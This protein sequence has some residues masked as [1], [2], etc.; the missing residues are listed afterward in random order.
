MFIEEGLRMGLQ[1]RAIETRIRILQAAEE[2]FALEGYDATGVAEICQEAGVSKGA[3]YH[4]FDSKQEVFLELLAD[5]LAEMDKQL[6]LL[7]KAKG[8]VPERI[9]SM[10]RV[11]RVV[12]QA[13][14]RGLPIY[15]E[16]WSRA[17]RDPEVMET[18]IEP[19]R[20]Y[21][22]FFTEMLEEGAQ[23][24]TLDL[25]DPHIAAQVVLSLALG[26]LVQGIFDPEGADWERV[27]AEGIG[28]VLK[29]YE[30]R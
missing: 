9:L 14:Q 29:G 30:K 21:R 18:M 13:A 20:K 7:G 15:L 12:L 16:F 19:F 26:L 8:N 1:Q 28:V 3:F 17:L 25:N 6:T 22:A 10:T 24:G 27:S 5:W 4:H 23:E 11:V 2:R